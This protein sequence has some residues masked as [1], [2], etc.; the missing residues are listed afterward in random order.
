MFQSDKKV[1]Q[2]T[3]ITTAFNL[4]K[5]REIGDFAWSRRS[6]KQP[7]MAKTSNKSVMRSNQG[8]VLGKNQ[9]QH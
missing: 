3:H 2:N 9:F 6:K 1:L 5:K 7:K 8:Y 4:G